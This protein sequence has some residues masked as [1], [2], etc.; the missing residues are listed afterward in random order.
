[1]ATPTQRMQL[2]YVHAQLTSSCP[3]AKTMATRWRRS[4]SS[5][6]SFRDD[7]QL[8]QYFLDGINPTGKVLGV[9][10]YGSVVEVSICRVVYLDEC[11]KNG[12]DREPVINYFT[13]ELGRGVQRFIHN[14]L[15]VLSYS[16]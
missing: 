12:V 9:G 8:Q 6:D 14:L 2:R 3:S 4:V 10:S 1:M 5:R 7:P 13:Y 15:L 16:L 11:I